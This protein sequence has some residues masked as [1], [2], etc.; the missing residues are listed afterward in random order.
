MSY[1][2]KQTNTARGTILRKPA[3]ESRGGVVSSQHRRASEIG[4]EVMRAGGN[5]YDAAVAVSFALGVLEPWMSGPFGG[6]G[7]MVAPAN[8]PVEA[9][10]YGM[11]APKRL[12][13][14]DYPLE[15]EGRASDLFPWKAVVGDR[16]VYG[17]LAVAV[18]GTVAGISALHRRYGTMP[19]GELLQPAIAAAREGLLMD[20]YA[21][22]MIAS[23]AEVLAS[24]SDAAALFLDKGVYPRAAGWTAL[25]DQRLNMS[26]TADTLAHI[27]AVGADDF[28]RGDLARSLIGDLQAKG[29]RMA[30]DDLESYQPEWQKPLVVPHNGAAFHLTP[31]LTAGPT[32][33]DLLGELGQLRPKA[34]TGAPGAQDYVAWARALQGAY[35][36]RLAGAGDDAP[37]AGQDAP[38]APSCTTHFAV[39]DADGN[40]LSMTQTLLSAFGSGVVSGSTGLL[41]NNGIMW[42]DPEQG[43]PNSVAPNKR[44]LM[45]ICPVYVEKGARRIALGAAGGRKIL[46]A[47]AQM[48]LLMTDHDLSPDEAMHAPRIDVSGGPMVQADVALSPEIHD[49][50]GQ[51]FD[52]IGVERGFFPLAYACPVGVVREEGM[53]TGVSEIAMP[54]AASVAAD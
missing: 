28:Y 15:A 8:G 37:E 29:S 3:V 5:A 16:N 7:M 13:P 12:D 36:R 25:S 54:W 14:A 4:V 48:T 51:E 45:N 49:A 11:K 42:F 1:K 40:M 44:C 19:W 38:N 30:L 43:N 46:P 41:M 20:W 24:D 22:L 35:K 2:V 34:P 9:L 53:N 21:M 23:R 52:T 33:A 27:A 26:R 18:P 39:V 31:R 6:G 47:V 10:Y 50:L 32:F 17:A